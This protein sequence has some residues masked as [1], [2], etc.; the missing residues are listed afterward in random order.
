MIIIV[1]ITNCWPAP[2]A[3][4]ARQFSF[5]RTICD[6][7]C[8]LTRLTFLCFCLV[9]AMKIPNLY[10][11]S[12][13]ISVF[14]SLLP[15]CNKR[16]LH[17][18]GILYVRACIDVRCAYSQII[19]IEYSLVMYQWAIGSPTANQHHWTYPSLMWTVEPRSFLHLQ[20]AAKTATTALTIKRVNGSRRQKWVWVY[21]TS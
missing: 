8:P 3:V 20:T 11:L 16:K 17:L 9:C 19:Q 2:L 15:R 6:G 13:E 5:W 10:I 1:K 4:A 21:S 7:R 14:I 12:S 18:F